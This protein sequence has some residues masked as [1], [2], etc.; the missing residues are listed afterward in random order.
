MLIDEYWPQVTVN[1]EL[2]L[3]VIVAVA[4]LEVPPA[5]VA[6]YWKLSE[7]E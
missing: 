5:F 7:P 6:V 2:L 4:A 3:T 1:V